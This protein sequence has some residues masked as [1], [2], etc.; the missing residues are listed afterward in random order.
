MKSGHTAISDEG[1]IGFTND[2]SKKLNY[3]I[4][5]LVLQTAAYTLVRILISQISVY[6]HVVMKRI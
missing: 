6:V 3:L 5:S 2:I 4:V 1:E